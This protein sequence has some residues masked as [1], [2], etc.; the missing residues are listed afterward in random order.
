MNLLTRLFL[1]YM[2]ARGHSIAILLP[3]AR[4]IFAISSNRSQ[5]F[6]KSARCALIFFAALG[7]LLLM[8]CQADPPVQ[9]MA[10]H[11]SVLGC[12]AASSASFRPSTDSAST[13]CVIRTHLQSGGACRPITD[14]SSVQYSRMHLRSS[15]APLEA[16]GPLV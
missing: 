13:V 15:R 12:E 16:A 9:G 1:Q 3:F 5:S 11:T 6:R 4:A 10:A 8:C 14:C 2:Q 7:C